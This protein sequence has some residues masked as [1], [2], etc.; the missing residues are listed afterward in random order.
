[1]SKDNFIPKRVIVAILVVIILASYT[2]KNQY[3][4]SQKV[5]SQKKVVFRTSNWLCADPIYGIN[6]TDPNAMPA[7]VDKIGAS[8]IIIYYKDSDT[9]PYEWARLGSEVDFWRSKGKE[10]WLMVAKTTMT[11]T[12]GTP[13]SLQYAIDTFKGRVHGVFVDYFSNIDP[14]TATAWLLS[15]KAQFASN[16]MDFGYYHGDNFAPD[17]GDPSTDVNATYLCSQG[18]VCM[19]WLQEDNRWKP[20]TFNL[21]RFWIDYDILISSG[22]GPTGQSYNGIYNTWYLGDVILKDNLENNT[23]CQ[24]LTF[25]VYMAESW[26]NAD[27][28]RGMVAAANDWLSGK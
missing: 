7:L 5:S 1:M 8:V 16:G 27:A 12:A 28:Q 22:S 4:Q 17:Y 3:Y 20:G 25:M 6:G 21:P 10:V 24:A 13:Y 14:I 11:E 15:K 18:L 19:A 2:Y 26:P 23:G 9:T